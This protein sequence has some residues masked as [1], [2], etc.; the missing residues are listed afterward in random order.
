MPVRFECH[1]PQKFCCIQVPNIR[2]TQNPGKV[3]QANQILT[4]SSR[5]ARFAKL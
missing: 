5:F 2:A 1:L 3:D 4:L